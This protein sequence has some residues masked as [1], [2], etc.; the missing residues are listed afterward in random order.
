MGKGAR[1]RENAAQQQTELN[2]KSNE[3]KK[4]RRIVKIA[5]TVLCIALVIGVAAG[6]A[7]FGVINHRAKTGYYL[8]NT[9]CGTSDNYTVSNAVLAYYFTA[10]YSDFRSENQN[11]LSAMG[12]D[13]GK[14]L[15]EQK[16]TYYDGYDTW[17]DYIMEQT[18]SRITNIICY[19]N[20]AKDEGLELD[21]SDKSNIESRMDEL[22]SAAESAD[23]TLDEYISDTYGEGLTEADIR[24]CFELTMLS[25]KY[26]NEYEQS[27][28]YTDSELESYY[29]SNPDKFDVVSYKSYTLESD[30]T[31]SG[32][33]SKTLQEFLK[34]AES[35]ANKLKNAKSVDE[36]DKALKSYLAAYYKARDKEVTEA[37]LAGMVK[38][39]L[40]EDYEYKEGGSITKW[41]FDSAR[42]VGDTYMTENEDEHT[43]TVYILTATRH[44]LDYNTK[45]VRHILITADTYG[46]NA[47]ALSMAQTLLDK[48]YEKSDVESTFIDYA[49][50][51]SEDPGSSSN[52]GLYENIAMGEM[53]SEFDEWC[54]YSGRK[55]GDTAVIKTDYGYHVMYFVGDG[56]KKWQADA[57]DDLK[58][59]DFAKLIDEL[60]AKYNVK[61]DMDA[62]Y[63]LDM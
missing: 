18:K 47:E 15:K 25:Q 55:T 1:K 12:V 11:Q 36:F 4:R 10:E 24:S 56:L 49:K 53:V 46:D 40:T 31:D 42:K 26:Y 62:A 17:Y 41:A 27:L 19:A 9:T 58:A 34:N 2:M 54:Y 21:D 51:Y 43:Y 30:R 45:N 5:V 37:E 38:N 22:K 13:T 50:E 39:T 61:F 52:G 57:V 14:P 59:D 7:V 48:I 63:K 44:R 3:M 29:N 8:R 6:G 35:D 20:A 33:N 23:K 32:S 16:C 28:K 60:T